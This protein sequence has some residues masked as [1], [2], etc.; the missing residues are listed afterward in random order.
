[1]IGEMQEIYS[2]KIK[3]TYSDFD[4]YDH[5]LPSSLQQHFQDIAGKHAEL[6]GVGYQDMFRQGALW[7]LSKISLVIIEDLIYDQEYT[8]KTWAHKKRL[9]YFPR[10]YAI[11][12]SEGKLVVKCMSTWHIFSKDTRNIISLKNIDLGVLEHV[13]SIPS[14]FESWQIE[15]PGDFANGTEKLT[16]QVTFTNLDHNGHMN[17]THYSDLAIDSLQITKDDIIDEY[18]IQ[19]LSECALG[20]QIKTQVL[21]DNPYHLIKGSTEN[22][23]TFRAMVKFRR[24]HE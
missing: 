3:F 9:I 8:L 10:E 2:E 23:E 19:F 12:D 14:N 24:K 11:Y 13:D 21:F 6:L 22:K 17:N 7:I 5:I 4:A 18:R 20:E 16:H 15:I 1:M